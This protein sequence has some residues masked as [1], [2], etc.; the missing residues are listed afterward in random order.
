MATIVSNGI[1]IAYERSGS[2]ECVLF[3]MGSG[4]AGRVQ[5]GPGGATM[6][7]DHP[8]LAPKEIP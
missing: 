4:A 5:P 2:G 1:R 3:I 7:A 6:R 8:P